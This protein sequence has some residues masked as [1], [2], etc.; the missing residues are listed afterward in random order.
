MAGDGGTH[1]GVGVEYSHV[2]QPI[3]VM[4]H[5]EPMITVQIHSFQMNRVSHGSWAQRDDEPFAVLLPDDLIDSDPPATK[6]LVDIYDETGGG[7]FALVEVEPENAHR[8][9]IV[10]GEKVGDLGQHRVCGALARR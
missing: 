10:T 5:D 6:Q 8:Y 7:S 1:D 4:P 3:S 9:G 2:H